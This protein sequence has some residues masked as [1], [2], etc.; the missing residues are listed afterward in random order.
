ME[1]HA[2]ARMIGA[3]PGYVGYESGGQLT[4][5]V[6]RHP[7]SVILLDEVEKAHPEVMNVLLQLLDDG[8]LTDGKGRVVDFRNTL[9][10]MTSNLCQD[11]RFEP[12]QGETVEARDQRERAVMRGAVAAL[13]AGVPEPARRRWCASRAWAQEQIHAIVR[14]ELQKVAR[15]LAE[16]EIALEV[17]DAAVAKIAELGWDP[18]FGARPVKRVIQREV[19]DR[20]GRCDPG[21]RGVARADGDDRREGWRVRAAHGARP[22]HQRGEG[23]TEEPMMFE[24]RRRRRLRLM[25]TAPPAAWLEILSRRVPYVAQL[26]AEDQREL[27]GKMQVFLAEKHFEGCGGLAMTDEIKVTIAAQ[28]C[29]LLLHRETDFY[30]DLDS[31]PRLPQRVRRRR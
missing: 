28:A 11:E 12:V 20:A 30:P 14:L 9:V 31:D 16:Q 1:R 24:T 23:L 3:P 19:Q 26:G 29:I 8:R 25:Q 17:T 4:E 21:R 10:V 2:V 15:S 5:A 18:R 7:Y 27:L 22:R 6:R 13:P